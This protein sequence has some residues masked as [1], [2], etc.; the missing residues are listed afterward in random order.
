MIIFDS[1]RKY[2]STYKIKIAAYI[3]NIFI[4]SNIYYLIIYETI[5]LR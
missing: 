2:K 4:N 1:L 5:R 3:P